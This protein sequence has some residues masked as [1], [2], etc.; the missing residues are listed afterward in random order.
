MEDR[1]VSS[2][3][4]S[5]VK[6]IVILAAVIDDIGGGRRRRSSSGRVKRTIILSIRVVR[7][8]EGSFDAISKQRKRT[9]GEEGEGETIRDDYK[10]VMLKEN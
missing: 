6:Q 7:G 9:N 3:R 1:R 5:T 2:I 8:Q 4:D 10:R